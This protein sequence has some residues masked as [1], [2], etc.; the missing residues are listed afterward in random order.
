MDYGIVRYVS[1]HIRR[2]AGYGIGYPPTHTWKII[3]GGGAS[4]V[5]QSCVSGAV[6]THQ[7]V[8]DIGI[9]YPTA[10]E[11]TVRNQ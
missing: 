3:T 5:K 4:D 8:R 6:F 10:F 11:M 1:S 9:P 7:E 2:E